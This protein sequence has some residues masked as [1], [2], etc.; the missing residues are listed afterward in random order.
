[1]CRIGITGRCTGEGASYVRASFAYFDSEDENCPEEVTA[2]VERR[3]PLFKGRCIIQRGWN[4]AFSQHL[5]LDFHAQKQK[6]L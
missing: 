6:P 4:D 5:G 2:F 1:M 3:R